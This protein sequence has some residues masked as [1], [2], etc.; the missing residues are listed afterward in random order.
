MIFNWRKLFT[1]KSVVSDQQP[2]TSTLEY[3][4]S[5]AE[6]F[7]KQ[8]VINIEHSPEAFETIRDKEKDVL[9]PILKRYLTGE[10]KLVLDFGCGVG[11]YTCELA[12]LTGCKVI[13]V[14][15]TKKLLELAPQDEHVEYRAIKDG[16]IPILDQ[17]VDMI[18]IYAVLGCIKDQDMSKVCAELSRVLKSG[19]TLF[20]VE[21]TSN[22]P[23][24]THYSYRSANGYI[25]LISTAQL[26][27]VHDYF[28]MGKSFK[29]KFSVL[30][31]KQGT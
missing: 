8:A 19:G 5:R 27:H 25:K 22:S 1:K 4:Q 13:G 30:V 21:N 9:F 14:D 18:W 29:E 26:T 28:D 6:K 7:G 15:P 3:W 17:S 2:T 10:E 11:R 24:S 12:K 16:V 31:G 23:N 20:V